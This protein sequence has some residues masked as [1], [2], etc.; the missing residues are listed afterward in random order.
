[1]KRTFKTLFVTSLLLVSL[2]IS[3]LAFTACNKDLTEEYASAKAAWDAAPNKMTSDSG[4]VNLTLGSGENALD[5]TVTLQGIRVYIGDTFSIQYAITATVPDAERIHSENSTYSIANMLKEG[6]TL[7][8]VAEKDASG[9]IDFELYAADYPLS[10]VLNFSATFT[11]EDMHETIPVLDLAANT[12]YDPEHMSTDGNSY[13]IP[14]DTALDW[15]LQ[16]LAPILAYGAGYDIMPMIYDWVD[17][18]DVTGEVTFADGNFATM[19]TSQDITGF[20][21]MEDAEFLIYNLEFFPMMLKNLFEKK[22]I[23][24]D[25]PIGNKVLE[26]DFSDIITDGVRIAGNVSTSAQYTILSSDATM[27]DILG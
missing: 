23:R 25:I 10:V 3:A 24:F 4:T 2:L 12:F 21:P 5:A 13:T 26:L 14:G 19:T 1:M 20:M 11:E 9:V 17:F 22:I 15:I 27:E 16:Q 7:Y 6:I 8:F 18:G